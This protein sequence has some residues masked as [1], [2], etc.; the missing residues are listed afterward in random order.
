MAGTRGVG[1]EAA[2]ARALQGKR[3]PEP[4]LEPEEVTTGCAS[5]A[6]RCIWAARGG[7][8]AAGPG[9]PGRGKRGG[10]SPVLC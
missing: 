7:S 5:G 3:P 4:E 6:G 8:S 9:E 10:G 1:R 2:A